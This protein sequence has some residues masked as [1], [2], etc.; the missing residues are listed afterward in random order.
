MMHGYQIYQIGDKTVKIDEGR[1]LL[2]PPLVE[3]KAF[4]T[5]DDILKYSIT[6]S[7]VEK[8][9]V[10]ECLSSIGS[11]VFGKTPDQIKDS[12]KRISE[13]VKS[14]GYM[15]SA[16]VSSRIFECIIAVFRMAGIDSRCADYDSGVDDPRLLLAKQYINDNITRSV[17]VS[18][19]A[20]YCCMSEKQI[21]R[22]FMNREGIS[23]AEY[24][25]RR[26]CRYIEGLLADSTLSLR[27]ISEMMEFNNEYYFNA[28]FK[29]YAGM[30]PGAYRRSLSASRKA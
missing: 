14:K 8:S 5:S 27:R 19:L 15:Y 30:S 22:I 11:Y 6:F 1:F 7:A 23:T 18:E 20:L 2:I 29:K 3:H 24:I 17:T 13:E 28:Y 12:L 16:I 26:R 9:T 10:S 25:K 4:K 21:S